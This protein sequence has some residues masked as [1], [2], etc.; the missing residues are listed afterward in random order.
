VIL[1]PKFYPVASSAVQRRHLLK[2]ETTHSNKY[3]LGLSL[4]Y[5]NENMYSSG[6]WITYNEVQFLAIL[7]KNPARFVRVFILGKE[8][9]SAREYEAADSMLGI[10]AWPVRF[11][12]TQDWKSF[13][14][15]K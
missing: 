4:K 3:F 1:F 14:H 12:V 9:R 2:H 10:P 8:S 11:E 6:N 13:G 7:H 15:S 5:N